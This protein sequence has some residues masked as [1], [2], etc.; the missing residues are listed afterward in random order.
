MRNVTCTKSSHGAATSKK[1]SR[2]FT[3]RSRLATAFDELAMSKAAARWICQT[4]RMASAP[5]AYTLFL[6]QGCL[7]TLGRKFAGEP[8]SGDVVDA[9]RAWP[10]ISPRR[11]MCAG[12]TPPRAPSDASPPKRDWVTSPEAKWLPSQQ[13]CLGHRRPHRNA[14]SASKQQRF[15]SGEESNL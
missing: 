10:R 8:A 3:S 15:S 2:A 4:R 1:L 5:G 7:P 14:H 13:M 11:E 12:P 6:K 9:P